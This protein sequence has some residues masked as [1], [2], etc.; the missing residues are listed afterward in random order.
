ML[1]LH[2]RYKKYFRVAFPGYVN[3]ENAETTRKA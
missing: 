3:K 2:F 1:M